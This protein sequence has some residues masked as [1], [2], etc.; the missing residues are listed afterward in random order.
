MPQSST[1]IGLGAA[2]LLGTA[3]GVQLGDSA[4]SLI[5]PIHFQGP[6][7]HPRERGAAL[8]ES[9]VAPA[10]PGFASAYGW[11]EGNAAIAADCGDCDAVLARDA[12]A[13]ASQVVVRPAVEQ[14]WAEPV[15][16][17]RANLGFIVEEAA[18]VDDPAE[19]K[20]IQRYAYYPIEADAD[21]LGKPDAEAE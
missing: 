19:R 6:A 9:L 18:P 13:E 10:Q 12:Y 8:D 4:I 11:D 5:H 20:D 16:V 3:G 14:D 2:V 1:L 7:V 21:D 15:R 17:H